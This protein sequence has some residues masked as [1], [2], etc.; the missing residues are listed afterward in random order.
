MLGPVHSELVAEIS[1]ISA[2]V[3]EFELRHDLQSAEV[4]AR[5]PLVLV[6]VHTH[7]VGPGHSRLPLSFIS[8]GCFS[9]PDKRSAQLSAMMVPS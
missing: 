4:I 6:F 2:A 8:I 7:V 3:P 9:E 1:P 5:V